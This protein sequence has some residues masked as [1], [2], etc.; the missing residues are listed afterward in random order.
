MTNSILLVSFYT[1]SRG[2]AGG[3]RLL[4]L[5]R[6]LRKV[7]PDLK[8]GL[9]TFEPQA[10]GRDAELLPGIF[11]EVHYVSAD[12]FGRNFA[13]DIDFSIKDFDFIDLQY[14]QCGAL[15]GACRKK[16]PRA[17]VAFSPMESM[18][19]ALKNALR[20]RELG[21][22]RFRQVAVG[23]FHCLQ[24]VAYARA[25]DRVITVS[26]PDRDV[27]KVFKSESDV[28]CI[29]TALSDLEFSA[30]APRNRVENSNVIV[31]F[32][33]FGSKTNRES[34]TW[35]CKNVHPRLRERVPDYTLRVVGRG[36][37]PELLGRC[38]GDGIEFRG[39]VE[40]IEDGLS[41]ASIGIAPAL[42]GAGI[43]G[44]I[45]QY[46]ILGIPSVV[47]PLACEG[48]EY[49]DGESLMVAEDALDFV[50]ICTELLRDTSLRNS[51]GR[52]A[53]EVCLEKYT[54]ASMRLPIRTAYGVGIS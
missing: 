15:I 11:D 54:W 28:F 30:A 4:D 26:P 45:H 18:V 35:Y 39:E 51:I 47:S 7:Q 53:R 49:K 1:P 5:Y 12:Y 21:A 9:V 16:W 36:L 24:E 44:K 31:F 6:E 23:L 13:S 29:P 33:F 37:D 25:A 46:S 14:H 38:V 22:F 50:R 17:V 48:L 42:G 27:I 20:K 52:C 19:R 3:L 2:H 34:L 43:R 10:E 40:L 8:L 41:G 32:A